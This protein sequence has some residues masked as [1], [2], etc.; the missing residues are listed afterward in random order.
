MYIKN[1]NLK[2]M[3]RG[4]DSSDGILTC[5]GLTSPAK[6]NWENWIKYEPKKKMGSV[7]KH[8]EAIKEA[9]FLENGSTKK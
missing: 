3:I 5:I 2:S 1:Y 8:W 4:S 9:R 7:G 6:K